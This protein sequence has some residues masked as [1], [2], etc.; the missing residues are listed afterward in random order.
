M[1]TVNKLLE[2]RLHRLW[3]LLLANRARQANIVKVLIKLCDYKESSGRNCHAASTLSGVVPGRPILLTTCESS[4]SWKC[5][6]PA[7]GRQFVGSGPRSQNRSSHLGVQITC[8]RQLVYHHL[9]SIGFYWPRLVNIVGCRESD[10]NLDPYQIWSLMVAASQLLAM[11]NYT[12]KCRGKLLQTELLLE[13]LLKQKLTVAHLSP[14]YLFWP[15]NHRNPVYGMMSERFIQSVSGRVQVDF[16]LVWYRVL[17]R[18]KT[19]IELA[20]CL[21]YPVSP[22]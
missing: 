21:K 17:T 1:L 13:M 2:E 5:L 4:I 3:V 20:T 10:T 6:N 14:V 8:F 12:S 18:D 22:P 19:A 9:I 16:L 7:E 11:R 15:A